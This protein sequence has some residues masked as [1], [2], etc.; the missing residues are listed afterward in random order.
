MR[1][2]ALLFLLSLLPVLAFGQSK[3][4]TAQ[5]GQ[6]Y[7][8]D[9]TDGFRGTDEM[10]LYSAAFYAQKPTSNS[11]IDVYVVENKIVEI[12]DRAGAVFLENKPDPG[13]IPVGKNGF[14]LSG[15]GAARRWILANLRV[16]EAIS[17]DGKA[18]VAAGDPYVY[19][20]FG[21]LQ[22]QSNK[23]YYLNGKNTSRGANLIVF[24]TSDFY[25]K[26]PPNEAG[27]DILV[28]NGKVA[29]IRDRAGAVFI[30]KKSDPGPLKISDAAN[31]YIISGN[32]EGRNWL[33]E[34]VK[35]G[36]EIRAS[37][38]DGK[39]V[40]PVSTTPCFEGAYY[41]KAVSS[42]DMWTGIAGFVKL[43][44]P[45]FDENRKRSGDASQYLDNFSVYMGGNAGGKFEVDAGLTWEFTMDESGKK[46]EKRNAFRPFWRTKSCNSAPAKKEFYFY[47]GETVQM[48]ILVAGPKKLRLVI[49][50]GKSKTFQTEF[51]AEGFVAGLP[52]QF[53]R[54]NAIDQF[55]NEGRPVQPSGAEITG[56]EWLNTILLRGEG[57]AVQQLPMNASRFTDMRCGE[58]NV[59]ISSIDASKGAEKI[60]LFGTPR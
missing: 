43:G 54:V 44:T 1:K 31:S 37:G 6:T 22:T 56:A 52:R 36:E 19:N 57:Q 38:I 26:T 29:E 51:E 35:T 42:F 59:V 4:V 40:P 16:G 34:N 9:G 30:Q 17:L 55:G 28:T 18:P 7:K 39:E 15:N 5:N 60:D 45:K 50:D 46:S 47:P 2:L 32:G 24:Y 12:R 53:K 13:P 21:V 25:Q 14:V 58:K 33:I 27:V 23:T 8:I 20:G 41:R 48:A 10:W 11:G 3:T 49:S